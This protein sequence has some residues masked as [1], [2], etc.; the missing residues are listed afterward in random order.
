MIYLTDN[1]SEEKNVIE[2]SMEDCHINMAEKN[3]FYKVI[4]NEDGKFLGC[5][6]LQDIKPGTIILQEKPQC[7]PKI[8][9]SWDPTLKLEF[10]QQSIDPD[11]IIILLKAYFSMSKSC[12]DDFMNLKNHYSDPNSL[13]DH[14]KQNYLYWKKFSEEVK[15]SSL[16]KKMIVS[17]VNGRRRSFASFGS[18]FIF[19]V[20]CIFVSNIQRTDDKAVLSINASKFNHSCG[21]NAEFSTSDEGDVEIKTTSKIKSGEEI[22]FTYR[23]KAMQ[24]WQER[25]DFLYQFYCIN[26][27]CHLCHTES[28]MF[29]HDDETYEKYRNLE[30]EIEH[31]QNHYPYENVLIRKL[32]MAERHINC[33]KKQYNIARNKK[34]QK[35]YIFTIVSETFQIGAAAYSMA[36][37][38]IEYNDEDVFDK[39]KF[40]HGECEI[41]AK[42]AYQMAKMVNGKDSAGAIEWKEISQDF[43]NWQEKN[44][45]E[46][47]TRNV[48]IN[49]WLPLQ[50]LNEING[51]ASQ[52]GHHFTIPP[53]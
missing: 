47:T 28:K 22:T 53:P 3:L 11:Y 21:T 12:M 51:I 6:A 30:K 35:C 2:S 43:D 34:A 10:T 36:Q 1:S 17:D 13:R 9:T 44:K 41:M 38:F 32:N 7:V 42:L 5:I 25:Q 4:K 14:H 16:A 46:I 29:K 20:I 26:C 33:L 24:T 52:G 50:T 19:D 45:D 31:I 8:F 48:A 23:I 27:N 18:G 15:D 49:M 39:M 40:F 37:K